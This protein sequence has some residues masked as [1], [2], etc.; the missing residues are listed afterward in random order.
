MTDE[1]HGLASVI[2][3]SALS[4][5]HVLV[6]GA[7]GTIGREVV[8]ALNAHGTEVVAFS[9]SFTSPTGAK[10]D[11]EG[12]TRSETDV[13]EVLKG[14]VAVVH[15]AALPH[16]EA[17]S[18]YEVYTTNVVST[19]NVLTHAAEAGIAR[20]VIASSIHASGIP[21]NRHPGVQ[22]VYPIDE[23]VPVHHDDWYSLSKYSD[24]CTAAMVASRWGMTI[25]ALRFPL[26]HNHSV[27]ARTAREWATNPVDGA[28]LGWSYLDVRDAAIAVLAAIDAEIE[29]AQVFQLAAPTTLLS[30]PTEKLLD[31]YAA[32]AHRR[33]IF[34]GCA[35]PVDI[36]RARHML[37][38][39]PRYLFDSSSEIED[40]TNCR[41]EKIAL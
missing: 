15:L 33:T 38:F 39:E 12:D 11:V 26:V 37:G 17:G 10:M 25:A 36:S 40:A 3:P 14:A 32:E 34:E 20:A 35:A 18:P 8:K 24:E 6:T 16:W 1:N 21:G 23:R 30:T 29:G 27:L 2:G 9:R 5:G 7:D 28:K 4:S 22:M 41:E 13:V 31:I 19:F